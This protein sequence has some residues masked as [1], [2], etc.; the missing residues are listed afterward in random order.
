M[1]GYGNE[2][3]IAIEEEDMY[4]PL[5]VDIVDVG[6]VVITLTSDNKIEAN[7]HYVGDDKD[8]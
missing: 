1:S 2:F 6:S 8:E 5:A 3:S 4:N 7:V